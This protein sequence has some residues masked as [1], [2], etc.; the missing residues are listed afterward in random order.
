MRKAWAV[1]SVLALVALLF[2]YCAD[3]VGT[4]E[5]AEQAETSPW[6]NHHDSVKYVG[7]ATCKQCHADKHETF[8]HTGMGLSFDSASREKSAARFHSIHPVYDSFS[9]FYYLPFWRDN[10]LFIKEYRL[11]NSDTVYAREQRIDYI[12]GS[13]Q[14]TN[15]HLYSSKGY[16]YQAP[17]TWYVQE[18]KWDL[19][20]GFE[21]G[22]NSRFNR[23]IGMEC[24][25]CHNALPGFDPASV[26]K[27]T[28]IPD[29]I[30]C[31]RC[32]GP[33]EVHV[34]Q[35]RA[36]ILVDVTK[37]TDYSIVNP[38]KLSWDRQVDLC[39]RC[40][41]QGNAVLKEGKSFAD[42]KP[43]MK[44]S[45]YMNVF[46]PR[47]DGADDEFIMASHAQRLQMSACFVQ[48]NKQS[49][50]QQL[51]CITCHNPHVSVKVT[52]KAV[53]NQACLN[54]H[55][56]PEACSEKPELRLKVSDNCVQCH[57]PM[58]GTLDIP[59]V[60]VHDHYIRKKYSKDSSTKKRFRGL[61]A[62]NNSNPDLLDKIKAYLAYYDKFE[63]KSLY[64]DS[65][66]GLLQSKPGSFTE[67]QIYLHYLKGEFSAAVKLDQGKAF[68][69]PWTY[70]RLAKAY[71]ELN[72]PQPALKAMGEAFN[73][74]KEDTRLGTEYAV[75]LLM[76]QKTTEAK[77]LLSEI[78]QKNPT[79]TAA[80]NNLGYIYFQESDLR[81][82]KKH[83]E[84]ALKLDPDYVPA[85]RNMIDFNLRIQ[86]KTEALSWVN[87]WL[88]VQSTNPEA[89]KIRETLLGR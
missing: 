31:E 11:E 58:Q 57:M 71:S 51:T 16:V 70:Y 8:I 86:N 15:S 9:N 45:D 74:L 66:A 54:C 48:S 72:L 1:L 30:D 67:Q 78:V 19:P 73:R 20:P 83:Y 47:Y 14:H 17:L 65:A 79:E 42:F 81:Q 75:L 32:H 56:S 62:V 12:V 37:E 59:H 88:Q 5:G 13:G 64:L 84:Q 7:M 63:A 46:M 43:G 4:D 52:G 27:F 55:T 29:G 22:A 40:H 69:D 53:F 49:N 21:Q 25:S 10:T 18:G 26:N 28:R 6:L 87:R 80:W 61:Y 82:A 33:G 77:S 3:H 89:L 36:G 35:K 44:L 34:Q 68:K 60:T 76:N 50:G 39:Q 85:F 2:S 38:A 23:L 24:M 41:L